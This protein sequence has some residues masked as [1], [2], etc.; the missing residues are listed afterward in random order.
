M[1][2]KKLYTVMFNHLKSKLL[3]QTG[4][5]MAKF[6]SREVLLMIHDVKSNILQ[7]YGVGILKV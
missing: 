1:A 7:N 3:A 5:K 4:S 6:D 2:P